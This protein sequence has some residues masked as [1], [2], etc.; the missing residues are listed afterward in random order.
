MN[1]QCS[2]LNATNKTSSWRAGRNFVKF[3][4]LDKVAFSNVAEVGTMSHMH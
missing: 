3:M 4:G 2:V 1:K